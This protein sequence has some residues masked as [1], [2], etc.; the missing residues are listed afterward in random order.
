MSLPFLRLVRLVSR[1][2]G[3]RAVQAADMLSGLR[4]VGL[5][6]AFRTEA[7]FLAWLVLLESE[8]GRS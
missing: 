8:G 2:Y 1:R 6:P 7:G 4:A 5:L 3:L